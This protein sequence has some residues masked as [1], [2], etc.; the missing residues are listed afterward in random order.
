MNKQ[1]AGIMRFHRNVDFIAEYAEQ[2]LVPEVEDHIGIG[3]A[4]TQLFG[5]PDFARRR[6]AAPISESRDIVD[7]GRGTHLEVQDLGIV[8]NIGV[9][10][11]VLE[12]IPLDIAAAAEKVYRQNGHG[13]KRLVEHFQALRR[14]LGHYAGQGI[15]HTRQ[16]HPGDDGARLRGGSPDASHGVLAL[17]YGIQDDVRSLLGGLLDAHVQTELHALAGHYVHREVIKESTASNGTKQREHAFP[18]GIEILPGEVGVKKADAIERGTRGATFDEPIRTDRF[19]NHVQARAIVGQRI[20]VRVVQLVAVDPRDV[21]RQCK[22]AVEL[23]IIEAPVVE[24][25]HD[26]P[27]M[28]QRPW[29]GG[30]KGWSIVVF[31]D[32]SVLLVTQIP[33]GMRLDSPGIG[34]RDKPNTGTQAT[35]LDVA[36]QP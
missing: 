26:L 23:V 30:I 3:I 5:K 18:V 6:L 28:V 27:D 12:S 36:G 14:D 17:T 32:V 34:I 25:R 22:L 15:H 20:D 4:Q 11:G 1:H 2:S 31:D 9:W 16:R 7:A 8:M 10:R 35:R 13:G 24:S 19:A 29:I 33:V 21:T